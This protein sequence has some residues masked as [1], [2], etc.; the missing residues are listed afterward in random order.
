M[1]V[2]FGGSGFLGA[3]IVGHLLRAGRGVRVATRHPERVSRPPEGPEDPPFEAVEA[4]IHREE[5][6]AAA[7]E[8]L[9]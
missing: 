8:A 4:D 2:V 1:I 7:L 9:R 6:V 5:Q 3:H